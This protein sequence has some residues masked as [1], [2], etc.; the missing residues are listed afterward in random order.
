MCLLLDEGE[1][2]GKASYLKAVQPTVA[3]GRLETRK[4]L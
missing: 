3:L 4:L 1:I 2:H